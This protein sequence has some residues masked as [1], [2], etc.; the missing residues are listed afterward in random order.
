VCSLE[1]L[2]TLNNDRLGR[3]SKLAA[4]DKHAL[5]AYLSTLDRRL[6]L[7]AREIHA[8]FAASN[9]TSTPRRR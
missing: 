6:S 4:E 9:V 8:N 5:V 7:R 1:E 2:I 3:T